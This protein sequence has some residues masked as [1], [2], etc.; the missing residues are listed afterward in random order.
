MVSVAKEPGSILGA[1]WVN[2]VLDNVL[3]RAEELF[4]HLID[5]GILSDGFFPF[6]EPVSA[7]TLRRMTAEQVR[8]LLDQAVTLEDQSEL[9]KMLED[10][11]ATIVPEPTPLQNNNNLL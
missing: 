8:T 10:L 3:D 11:P 9:L 1:R 5:D 6:E 4:E 7:T 2:E